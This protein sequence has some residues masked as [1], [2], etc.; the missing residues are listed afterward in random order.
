MERLGEDELTAIFQRI[1]GSDDRRSF[2]QVSKQFLSVACIRLL[3]LYSS[4]PDFLYEILPASPNLESFE[5]SKP[6]S[7]THMKLLAQSCP[8][9]RSLN[10]NSEVNSNPDQ[11]DLVPGEFDFN[12]DG[13][14]SV[15][16][17]CSNLYAVLLS[18]RSYIGDV[19]V[20]S[21]IKQSSKSLTYLDLS[22]CVNVT[23]ESLKAIGK[24]S[25]LRV[26]SLQGC[27]LITDLGLSYL[28]NGNV[29]NCLEVLNLAECDKI[30]D[31]GMFCLKQMLRLTDLNLSKCGVNVT[32]KGILSLCQLP[33]IERLDL[34]W[35]INITDMTLTVIASEF[36]KLKA[37]YLTGCKAI[38]GDGLCHF[39]FH[40]TLEE[41][42]LFSCNNISGE[43]VELLVL[44]CK[45]LTY[46]GVNKTMIKMPMLES[47][48]DRFY[49][50]NCWIDW[51]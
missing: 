28:A 46:L 19:G 48:E 40:G 5:C 2:H 31:N 12:D 34:S 29:R 14:C 25:C 27:R 24:A 47:V 10:L 9:L 7:N 6:L 17:A 22:R 3:K 1:H 51:Q 15:V 21:L 39:A 49:M 26:L 35:L 20:A 18:Q 30:S 41:L 4:V 13:L 36:V 50:G 37:L 45:K 16:N 38:S 33:N 43:N 44:T 8:K 42:Q 32:S 23:D 11:A